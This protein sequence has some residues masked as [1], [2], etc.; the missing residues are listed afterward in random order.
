MNFQH[1]DY[2][3]EDYIALLT[4]DRPPVNALNRELVNEL[5]RAAEKIQNDV[6]VGKIRS[7]IITATG[8]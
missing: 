2:Q 6:D 7:V 4:I 5:G 3:I 1:L 8:K